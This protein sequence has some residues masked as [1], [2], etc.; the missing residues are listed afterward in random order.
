M[1]SVG[2]IIYDISGKVLITL[3]TGNNIWSFPK[4]LQENNES[5]IETAIR[6]VYEETGLVL[7][8]E[9]F[10]TNF[11]TQKYAKKDKQLVLLEYFSD[12]EILY[13]DIICTSYFERNGKQ[14]PENC[15]YM[16]VSLEEAYNHVHEA[17]QK[18]LKQILINNENT[19]IY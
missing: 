4:G 6:E 13:N 12:T 5:Y 9:L 2:A 10:K 7:D 19:K 3:P 15:D 18:I 16:W 1:I 8:T 14:F 11:Y 17:Q